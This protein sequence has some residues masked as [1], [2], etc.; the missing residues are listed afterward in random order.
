MIAVPVIAIFDIG[1]TN[2]KFFLIDESYKIVLE[3]SVQFVEITDEDGDACDDVNLL[4]EWVGQTLNEILQL[5]KFDV[6]AVNFSAYGA[7]LVYIN[8]DGKVIAPL[9]SYLKKYPEQV[10][11]ELYKKYGGAEKLSCETASPE[12]GSL[13]SG[14]QLYR[15]MIEKPQLYNQVKYALHLP[16]YISYLISKKAVSDITSIGCHTQLWDYGENNYHHWVVAEGIEKKLAPVQPSHETNRVD[17]N[18]KMLEVGIGLHDSSAALIP[19]LAVFKE[20]FV[21][22]STGTW[23]ISLNPFNNTPLTGEELKKDCLCYMEYQGKPVKASR[24]FAGQEH[25]QQIKKL[26]KHFNKP[27]EFYKEIKYSSTIISALQKKFNFES[28]LKNNHDNLPPSVFKTRDLSAFKNYEEAYHCLLL[29]IMQQQLSSTQ[30]VISGSAVNRIFV[31]GGFSNNS[32]YMHLLA[33]AFPGLEIYAASVA[34][35]TAMGAALAIHK[36]WNTLPVPADMVKL[37]YYNVAD[38]VNLDV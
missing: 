15:M 2:K 1:K 14:M 17:Y 26:A 31:D 37:K 25:E 6:K 11:K 38:I 20:P 23:C 10:K 8:E 33:L 19:Y 36:E 4:T 22:I 28:P 34:Q 32:I 18:G 24:L 30:L 3:R 35:A 12:L 27:E 29:D 9:Y 16:Q 7:S 13:N 21:L 5:K